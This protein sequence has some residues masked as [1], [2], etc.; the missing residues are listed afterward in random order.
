VKAGFRT[1]FIVAVLQRPLGQAMGAQMS[2]LLA[3]PV[4]RIASTINAFSASAAPAPAAMSAALI[5]L[6]KPASAV[7][8]LTNWSRPV[9]VLPIGMETGKV[10]VSGV[11]ETVMAGLIRLKVTQWSPGKSA[12]T[13]PGPGRL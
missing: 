9:A 4:A 12:P 3:T 6:I 5:F 7:I 8:R 2:P 11:E 13:R 10:V 1:I